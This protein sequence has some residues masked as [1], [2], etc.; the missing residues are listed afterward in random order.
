M[1]G[2]GA[3]ICK[4]SQLKNFCDLKTAGGCGVVRF[5]CAARLFALA[6]CAAIEP[7]ELCLVKGGIL[8]FD[9]PVIVLWP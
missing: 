5:L 6:S 4:K 7:I 2:S 9:R 3:I 1:A 8:C